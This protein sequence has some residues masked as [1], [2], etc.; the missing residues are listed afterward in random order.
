MS[1]EKLQL[2]GFLKLISKDIKDLQQRMH[3]MEETVKIMHA[4]PPAPEKKE[5]K[6][7]N[8]GNKEDTQKKVGGKRK[9]TN[10]TK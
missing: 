6:K 2:L 1:E 10:V 8:V 9:L 4:A 7:E 3:A 5:V